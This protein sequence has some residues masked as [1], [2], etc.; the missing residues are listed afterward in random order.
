[1][2]SGNNTNPDKLDLNADRSY[3]ILDFNCT[4]VALSSV[5]VLGRL[6]MRKYASKSLGLDDFAAVISLVSS[7]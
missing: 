3:L 2:A 6:Y 5:F 4:L 7:F 1:M